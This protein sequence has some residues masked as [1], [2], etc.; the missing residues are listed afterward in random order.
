M[1]SSAAAVLSVLF[2]Y[3]VCAVSGVNR[4][5]YAWLKSFYPTYAV[6]MWVALALMALMFAGY[7]TKLRR[8]LLFFGAVA[9][10]L[11][12]IVAYNLGPAIRDGS[13]TRS[14]SMIEADGLLSYVEL[15]T[16]YPILL[17]SPIGGIV[18]AAA[19]VALF[20]STKTDRYRAA[21]A[22]GVVIVAGWVFFL[23]R[24]ALPPHW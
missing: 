22:G 2:A 20:R 13:F 17:L 19:F 21:A 4:W 23:M 10:H 12:G 11:A 15:A 14:I 8:S 5:A 18:A 24:G 6:V 3:L 16:F 7:A 1:T 9:G